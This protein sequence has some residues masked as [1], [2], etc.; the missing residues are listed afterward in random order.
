MKYVVWSPDGTMVALLGKHAVVL[1]DKDLTQVCSVTETVR[2]KSGAWDEHGVFIYTT[3]NHVK[4]LL[5]VAGAGEAGIVRTLD[6][7]VYAAEARGGN[8]YVVD[9]D[10]KIKALAI[11]ATEHL[12]K[13]ALARR[14]FDRV[15]NIIKSARLCGQA[16]IAYL[17]KAGYPEIALLFV[18]DD[19]TRFNLALQ[20]G[21]LD[22]ALKAAK[23]IN[24]EE[25]WHRLAAEA[26]K[27]G[28]IDL[29]EV[30]YQAS[31]ALERLS[32]LYTITGNKDKMGK[33][34]SIASV[35][36]D[37]QS[38]FHNALLVGDAG[39]RVKVL[40]A[41]GQTALAY[42][43]AATHG[44]E[45][46]AER[47]K[48]YLEQA[49]LPVPP[50]PAK[51]KPLQPSVA[52]KT[53]TGSIEVKRAPS[54]A[55]EPTKKQSLDLA[56]IAAAAARLAE[57]QAASGTSAT[58]ASAADRA[59]AAAAQAVAAAQAAAAAE[60]EE[61]RAAAAAE[62]A[63][64]AAA[65]A[66]AGGAEG[67]D[68]GAGWAVD[69]DLGLP[70][71]KAGKAGAAAAAGG[72][73]WGDDDLELDFA[74][75]D[76]DAASSAASAAA[77]SKGTSSGDGFVMPSGGSSV[78]SL[79][80]SNSTVAGD[81]VAAGSFETAMTLL[82]RQIGLKNFEPLKPFFM[83]VY[84][85]ARAATPTLPHLSSVTVYSTRNAA[86]SPPPGDKTLPAIAVTLA[87]VKARLNRV[88]EAFTEGKFSECRDVLDALF[89]MVPLVVVDRKEDVADLK[90][91]IK[92]ATEYKLAVRIMQTAKTHDQGDGARQME[93]AAYM[94]HCALEPPHLLLALNLAMRV[95]YKWG[96]FILA[97]GFARR[98]MEVPE[99][100]SAKNAKLLGDVSSSCFRPCL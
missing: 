63:A 46:D 11:D 62:K 91:S 97:A 98:L 68:G 94:T 51:S 96:N 12:F 74:A 15:L 30:C 86:S 29:T 100:N 59:S 54:S 21:N 47:I 70:E 83:A 99:A 67:G 5:P 10:A 57:E 3:L 23:A 25:C 75:A 35:R 92:A 80:V 16:V 72:G 87:G 66:E 17:Q 18:E 90:A 82:N 49:G 26:M 56:A 6:Q 34:M 40:E 55:A 33:M 39:E 37:T 85:G 1:A 4:Y 8:L 38:R 89:A 2:V 81:H 44:L 13:L 58:A 84:L 65:S 19:T 24:S 61:E 50:I 69:L 76:A 93:L 52:S 78:P 60:E 71:E 28:S 79:W 27:V 64:A 22:I 45:A 48:G 53:L 95:C 88:H 32:F 41:A 9:R 73:G 20:C 36:G 14:Q 7:P 42:L 31:K 77:A 43:T